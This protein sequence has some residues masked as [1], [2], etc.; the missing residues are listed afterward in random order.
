MNQNE[1]DRQKSERLAT[2]SKIYLTPRRALNKAFLKVKP[3]R[4]MIDRYKTNMI[5][6][7][8]R[9]ND[10]ESEEFHK[11]LISEFLK[12]TYF[13]QHHYI[14]TKGRND[15]VVHNGAKVKS[16]VGV[17][18]EV[19][20][21]TNAAEMPRHGNLN[22]K[23]LRELVLYYLRERIAHGNTE[24]KH[25]I[26]TNVYEWFIFDAVIFDRHFAQDK[27]LVQLFTDFESGRLADTTTDFFYREIAQPAIA[28]VETELTYTWLDL[29][30]QENTLRN[31][32]RKDD[33]RLIPFYKIFSPEHLLKLAF[34]NDSNS[35]DRRFYAELLH[36][37]GLNETKEK[38]KKLIERNVL[39]NRNAG[40]LL[41][42]T[43][44]QLDSLDKLSRLKN[45]PRYGDSR[46]ERLFGVSLEL[47]ITWVNRILFLKLLE[48]RLISYH[49]GDRGQAFLT[50]RLLPNYDEVNK[51]FFQVL[52][53]KTNERSTAVKDVFAQVP[54][55]NSSL[56]EP[57]ELEHLSLMISNLEDG[58]ELPIH[59]ATVLK[60]DKG[61][62]LKGHL[63]A[64]TYLFQFLDAYDFSGDGG[65][66]I[67][68]ENKS[69][70]NASVL[71][72]IFEK[73]NGYKDGSFFTPGFITMYMSRE[74]IRKAV[75]KKFEDVKGWQCDDLDALYEKIEDRAEANRIVNDI[76]ICDPAV[77]SGHFL[78]SALNEL[79]SIKHDLKILSDRNGR[80]L[81]EY[82]LEVVSDELVVTDEEGEL[83][84]YRPGSTESQRLQET[85]F[86]EKQTI[87][88]N[89][90]FGVDI[91]ANSVKICRL[92][93]WIELLKNAYYK[94]SSNTLYNSP[95]TKGGVPE[96]GGG[97]T[98]LPHL[99]T[100]RKNLRN[101]L[102][103][104]EA[105]LWILLKG[106]QLDDRKFR[107]Q[108]SV[109]NYI[110][111]FYCPEERLAIEL[112]GQGHFEASQAERDRERD[113][114]LAHTG[115]KVLRFENKWVWDRPLGLLDEVRKSFGWWEAFEEQGK[116]MTINSLGEGNQ[117]PRPADT[118]SW[119]GGKLVEL[120]TLPNIDINIKCGNSLISRF[121]MDASLAKALRKSK[122]NIDS[123]RV[124]VQ[125]YRNAGNKEQKHEMERLIAEIKNDFSTTIETPFIKSIANAR[126]KADK[127]ATEINTRRQWGESL[128]GLTK[129]FEKATRR[130]K[131]LE[132][133][134]DDIEASKIFQN[135]FEWRFEF[136]EVL[137][138]KGN[139]TGFDAVIGNPP[140]IR[141]EEL[142][143]IKPY[144]GA[145]YSTYAGT[146]DLYV[147]FVERAMMVLK[148]GGA[149][150]YIIPNKWMR[151]GYGKALRGFLQNMRLTKII[152]FGDLPVFE[153]ATTYPCILEAEKGEP[154]EHF[155]AAEVKALEYV[156]GRDFSYHLSPFEVMTSELREEGWTLVPAEVQKLLAKI[157]SKGTP[158]GEYVE[159]KIYRGVLTGLNEA[160][161]IDRATRDRLI[162]DDPRSAE[163]I[164]P[165]LA[166][167]DIKRYAQPRSERF[168]IVFRHGD[169]KRIFGDLPEVEA[170]IR[171]MEAFPAVMEYLESFE[172][173][174]K[175]R[176]DKGQYWWELRAC[177][178]YGEFEKG[179]IIV[180]A[181]VKGASY[182]YDT[183]SYYSNDKTTVIPTEDLS[184]LA[185]LNSKVVDFY[186]KSIASTKQNGYFEY[187][188]VYLNQLPIIEL[189]ERKADLEFCVKS[190]MSTKKDN[191]N[192]D[193]SQLEAK[194]DQVIFEVFCLTKEEIEII[195]NIR[196]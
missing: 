140:Y 177:D 147:Y 112:D 152:D 26:A 14:N 66:E 24:I 3:S 88:E 145:N 156:D 189:G 144:L 117:P 178:Y 51:L 92:R 174:A 136:P 186:F 35:L 137:D 61:R 184:L 141:Q 134:R 47:C 49:K 20:K 33:N 191:K 142:K 103:T 133:E 78:V 121:G 37:L 62:K 181:I 180:P 28:K 68:E 57:T 101:N 79:I 7:L 56:F 155:Q 190:I 69:L 95:S 75:L 45:A 19:K 39:G 179:K 148:N 41:E 80:R 59:S 132:A 9:T 93:L 171:M 128:K 114:F 157:R 168:L 150:S 46:E 21:P 102:T 104:A 149:M 99:K 196:E 138:E 116:A 119:K 13:D 113:L 192:A 172:A 65:E 44:L 187:K 96:G 67:Q 111:D 97:L 2:M 120:Q 158:L 4:S 30:N 53:R 130:L 52:A 125:T 82:T 109:A 108:H 159:G 11:N 48:S 6:L 146:A 16:T 126:G 164:K 165:F 27:K 185:Q 124:A 153:E 23:A 175:K 63:N 183:Q 38:G 50:P 127:L 18:L 162:A 15:L 58:I 34:A 188:P 70:I 118:P 94:T 89:C 90:L 173:K 10:L 85:L 86:H 167:R 170:K 166:G 43:I 83:F 8:D 42:N 110:L 193:T 87:I 115:I 60:D 194:I 131:K 73:I 32:A 123:Y 81:K 160:F 100:F 106:R 139:F 36:I 122:W 64:L 182:G 5:Q 76:R 17:I 22:A 151:A 29:R 91:N 55:L 143:E 77:G 72:L 163:V 154:A 54:Y 71:G 25:L 161:V 74:T 12:K 169:T 31:T 195:E 107:R 135:A 1:T 84:E 98:N 176:Y 40:S 105:K 129:D